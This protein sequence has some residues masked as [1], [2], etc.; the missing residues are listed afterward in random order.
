MLFAAGACF[1]PSLP[2]AE[3]AAPAPAVTT[4]PLLTEST[5][6]YHLPPF[7]LIKD[8][9]YTPAFEAGMAQQLK[10]V[11]T[12]ANNP[13]APTFE[14]TIV[15][16]ER[17]GQLLNRVDAIFSN[18]TGAN[19]NPAMEAIDSAMAPRLAAHEDSIRLNSALFA[20]IETLF[21]NRKDLDL[22]HESLW[23][24]ERYYHDFVR[25]G[26]KLSD[27]DKEK[28]KALNT[29]I[30]SLQTQFSQN[31]QKEKNADGLVVATKAELAGLSE[32]EIAAAA[33]KAAKTHPGQ[34]LLPLLNTT[35]Q[36]ALASLQNR[37]VRERLMAASLARGSHGGPYD[38]REV[39]SKLVRA[40]AER[41]TLL[42]YANHAE[43]QLEDQ[44]AKTVKTVNQLLGD[45]APPAVAN[46]RKE[47]AAMQAIIDR[48]KGGFTL[49]AADWAFYAEKV[50][51]EQYA[52]D[53]SQLRPYFELNHVLVDGVFYAA[54]QLYGLSFKERHDLP[55]Y[56]PD[57]RV[58]EV[59]DADGSPLALILID[60]Y[61]RPSKRG[62]AWMNQYVGQSELLGYKP[63][64]ANHLNIP[65]PP[66][67][68]PTL[69]TADEVKTAFHEFGHALHGMFSKVT[70]PRFSGTRVP[71]DFVEF[72][73]QFNEMW[74]FWPEVL[75][76]YAK[77]YQTGE[78]MPA[79][80]LAKLMAS[81]KFNQ[82]YES[83]EQFAATLLD[84]A[85]YQ[86]KPSEVP[87][88]D[89]VLEFEAA[90]LHKV[91]MDFAPVPPRYRSTYFSHVF[92]G[93]YSAGYYSYLWSEVLAADTSEWFATHGGLTRANGDRFRSMLLSRGG[94]QDA[95]GLFINFTGGEPRIEPL[96]K[97]R[98]L[99]QP[100]TPKKS[101]DYDG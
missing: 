52:F 5:L 42:G 2:A 66:D 43:Y 21:K 98:G 54:H 75:Q 32:A 4:N 1:L 57:V 62:G 22:N 16:L 81:Q 76:H 101:V 99:E 91:G 92:A 82:G 80:L 53:A 36:P 34:Y 35:G 89:G 78:P 56:H 41:A 15:A 93:G 69:L 7:D 28:L 95:M 30:A 27:A 25:A 33:A 38:N 85:W 29:D 51:A 3:P 63:V 87:G 44:T 86:L 45:L 9:H 6:P 61:A 58:F 24:L 97:K 77:H 79:A 12:I 55:V 68:Q 74:R 14:N 50:R 64:V 59:F 11:A 26:A 90:A 60:Y 13:E 48:E 39:V 83:T 37:G 94:S 96:L 49:D 31:V 88:A 46:A 73:S 67:G 20:R 47:A 65:K 23:L 84:Q 72:P 100:A 71:R 8:E 17:S 70:Y 18:L 10:E 19:T 40:R